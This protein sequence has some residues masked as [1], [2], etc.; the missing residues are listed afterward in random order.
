MHLSLPLYHIHV[1]VQAAHLFLGKSG[2]LGCAVLLCLVCL[3]DLA[4]FFLSHLSLKTCTCIYLLSPNLSFP[5]PSSPSPSSP[6][7]GDDFLSTLCLPTLP[8][9]V[10]G[11]GSKVA[12]LPSSVSHVEKLHLYPNEPL[13]MGLAPDTT[14]QQIRILTEVNR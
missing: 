3:F 12:N 13:M 9:L 2:C 5:L 14:V 1:H 10:G 8:C 6:V 11:V 7:L 4:C